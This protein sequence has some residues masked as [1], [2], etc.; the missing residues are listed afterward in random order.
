MNTLEKGA[1][2][3]D[4]ARMKRLMVPDVDFDAY[5]NGRDSDDHANVKPAK[6]FL[7]DMLEHFNGN[8]ESTG[9]TLPWFKTHDLIRFRHSEVTVW[10]GI[11]GHG[12]SMLLGQVMMGFLQKRRGCIASLEMKPVITLIRMC[13][14]AFGGRSPDMDYVQ[15]FAERAMDK[16]W[17]YDQ[18]GTVSADK[19]IQVIYYAAEKLQCEHFIVDSL[20]KCGLGEDDYNGQKRFVDRLCAAAKDTE[21]HIH[22][23]THARKGEDE[24]TPPN[25]MSVKGTGSI[26]DQVDNVLTVWRNKKKEHLI[27]EGKADFDMQKSPD[28]LL[29][30]DKQRNGEHEPRIALWFDLPSMRY[31]ETPP[32][33]AEPF[34]RKSITSGETE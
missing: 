29:I 34:S 2:S 33:K 27:A 30:C 3:L 14:Q 18:Q 12:K 25:K 17:L 6:D 9:D 10:N 19:L 16:L 8:G 32:M 7:G 4:Q 15:R 22:L 11:N 1:V 21:C 31:Q 24:H 20:L 5:M 23:V 13:R 28:A 26:T